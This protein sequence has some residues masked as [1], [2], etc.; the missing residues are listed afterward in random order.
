MVPHFLLVAL[1]EEPLPELDQMGLINVDRRKARK[2]ALHK[3]VYARLKRRGTDIHLNVTKVTNRRPLPA[4]GL[5]RSH[6]HVHPITSEGNI[7]PREAAADRSHDM[8]ESPVNCSR[9]RFPAQSPPVL[10]E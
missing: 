2:H 6:Q 9:L 4:G 10:C 7:R 5:P 3:F 1:V 8:G